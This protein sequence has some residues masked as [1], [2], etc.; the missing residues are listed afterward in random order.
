MLSSRAS[1]VA[2]PTETWIMNSGFAL[3]SGGYSRSGAPFTVG[4]TRFE[5]TTAAE[6]G[7]GIIVMLSVVGHERPQ[8]PN[9]Q[10]ESMF[11]IGYRSLICQ[12]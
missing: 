1:T 6:T 7:P 5:L 4:K 9:E 3:R 10:V 12:V 8:P 11:R 2:S